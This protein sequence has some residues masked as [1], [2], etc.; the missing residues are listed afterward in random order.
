MKKFVKTAVAFALSAL[1]IT[2]AS[3]CSGIIKSTVEFQRNMH[4]S[5]YYRLGNVCETDDG[6]YILYG[7]HE[8]Y[9]IEK[10]THKIALLCTKPE[11][12]HNDD[13]C[14]ADISG[15]VLWESGGRLYYTNSTLLEEH[16]K[17]VDHGER[18]YSVA[19]DGTD[20][21]V[22]QELEFEPSGSSTYV[23]P[24]LH[25]GYVYFFYSGVLYR[26]PLGG[27]I[28]KRAEALWGEEIEGEAGSFHIYDSIPVGHNFTLWADGDTVYFMA[29]VMQ[30]DGTYKDTLFAF[31]T[32]KAEEIKKS[33]K[34]D[35]EA[36]E[37]LVKQIWETPDADVVGEWTET[38]VSVTKWYVHDGYIYFYL[39]GGDYWRCELSS[40]KY[41]KLADTHGKT[42][43]G[44]AI[45]SDE[46]MCLLN[47]VPED[48]S[49][50]GFVIAEGSRYDYLHLVGGDT[51]Y[52]Y[53]LDGELLCELPLS[54][55]Y[56]QF[57][58]V[59][60]VEPIFC[61]DGG[62]Y[63]VAE[64]E[65]VVGSGETDQDNWFL[66]GGKKKYDYI[67]CRADIETGEI[68][69]IIDWERT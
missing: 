37:P 49:L 4:Q 57:D 58:G 40:G 17:L 22:V 55:V 56:E 16:G 25:R 64:A 29:N 59:V 36:D 24:I 67:L 2:S 54:S 53:G 44:K 18:I 31:D 30:S 1:T 13:T 68:E 50:P 62:V 10:E 63:F 35:G 47:S 14:N 28:K 51:F 12:A 65:T 26:V 66:A 60:N 46:Y 42:P 23:D 8:A 32:V 11:C 45:F 48:R 9:F 21:R 3:S 43:Y 6:Y 33:K 27:K 61:S 38:G 39:S 7:G 15:G 41:E 34:K 5:D 69:V 19:L 52:V 20:R